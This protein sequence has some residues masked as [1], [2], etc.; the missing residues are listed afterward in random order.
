MYSQSDFMQPNVQPNM[1]FNGQNEP[2][3][4]NTQNEPWSGNNTPMMQPPSALEYGSAIMQPLQSNNIPETLSNPIYTPAFLSQHIGKMVKVEF[5]VNNATT[6]RFG[7]LVQVGA[8]YIVLQSL[9]NT[10]SLM[11]D[12]N[13]VTFVTIMNGTRNPM[14][15]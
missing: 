1:Q 7:R 11:G 9:D 5:Q 10:S 13:A 3:N 8:N 4:D 6:E 2:W 15:L 12:L 14:L